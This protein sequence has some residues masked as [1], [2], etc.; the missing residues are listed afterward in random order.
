MSQRNKCHAPDMDVSIFETTK[1]IIC[2]FFRSGHFN[3]NHKIGLFFSILLYHD[4]F[5][6][7]RI[8]LILYQQFFGIVGKISLWIL[9]TV[10]I[11][12]LKYTPMV[13]N[14]ASKIR[15]FHRKSVSIL[16]TPKHLVNK[17][18]QKVNKPRPDTS[19]KSSVF[20][21][22][23]LFKFLDFLKNEQFCKGHF[24]AFYLNHS[25][26]LPFLQF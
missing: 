6:S 10:H 5:K 1:W 11:L 25:Q 23:S 19:Y 8:F 17:F 20:Y 15:Y 4:R 9:Y 21:A 22:K 12:L 18:V 16:T 26:T 2:L 13:A 7:S 3:W 14:G 24:S